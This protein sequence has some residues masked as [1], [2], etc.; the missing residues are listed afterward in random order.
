MRASLLALA[1]GVS[2]ALAAHAGGQGGGAYVQGDALI[3]PG[4]AWSGLAAAD[5]PPPP[6]P[7]TRLFCPYPHRASDSVF[8]GGAGYVVKD[9]LRAAMGCR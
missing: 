2:G 9:G 5:L 4:P 6:V 7:R 3:V 1:I 8:S